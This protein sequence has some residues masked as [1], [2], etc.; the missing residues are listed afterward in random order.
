MIYVRRS[1]YFSTIIFLFLLLA[2]F[3]VI[4]VGKP[5]ISYQTTSI[6]DLRISGQIS[7]TIP[8]WLTNPSFEGIGEPWFSDIEGD[9]SDVDASITTNQANFEVLGSAGY[10]SAI[11]G[12]PNATDWNEFNNTY[13][14][15]PDGSHEINEN[16]CEAS[17][18]F[19][20]NFDQSRNRP[21][22]HWRN[23]ITVPVNMSDYIITSA[24]LSAIING[25][26]DNNLE[27]PN[28]TFPGTFTYYDHAVFYVEI[29]NLDYLNLHRVA[30][31]KTINLGEGD[32]PGTSDLT[33][34]FMTVLNE[35][36]LIFYLTKALEK[37]PTHFG[38]TLGI[39]IY[40]EDNYPFADLDEFDSL[41]IKSVNLSFTYE[42]KMNQLTTVSWNQN[43][44]MINGTRINSTV[45][46]TQANLNFNYKISEDWTDAISS[47]S[48]IRVLINN[49]P[50][51]E[52]IK[53]SSATTNFQLAKIGGY[54]LLEIVFPYVDINFSIQV[55]LGDEFGLNRSFTISV[56][57][58]IF[59]ISYTETFPEDASV[60]E[61][62]IFRTLLITASVIALILGGYL[63]AYQRVLKYPH[64]VRKVR[65]FKRTLRRKNAPSTD[66]TSRK[67]AFK[68]SY[69]TE[70][71]GTSHY[72]RG[73]PTKG[74]TLAKE[75][76]KT[77]TPKTS[78]KITEKTTQNKGG[79]L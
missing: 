53:L 61:P 66:I 41:L 43:A 54:D 73:R 57:D 25:S 47:N 13:F 30:S 75:G 76:I 38:I 26:A 32:P 37:D 49:I 11:S 10:F 28:D 8:E 51:T 40:C 77:S 48:E 45:E 33:D 17:H 35:Q 79:A 74:S 15:L 56:D 19:N 7:R 55:I 58:V 1:F 27:T 67:K 50:H 34:T 64:A 14:I 21:S 2:N 4:P 20:E 78:E 71:K 31:H 46:F 22:V 68:K 6:N 69:K 9:V 39:D 65:K 18:T 16:G 36:T 70:I 63:L 62:P 29:S 72:L 60:E 44:D 5:T 59:Q 52:T 24:S 23:N 42:K 12:T 3:I